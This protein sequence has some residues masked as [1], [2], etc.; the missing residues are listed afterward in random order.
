MNRL[1]HLPDARFVTFVSSFKTSLAQGEK[2]LSTRIWSLIG[3]GQ[4]MRRTLLLLAIIPMVVVLIALGL[5]ITHVVRKQIE[6]ERGEQLRTYAA[7]YAESLDQSVRRHLVDIKS[8]AALL[9]TFNLHDDHSQLATWMYTVQSQVTDYAWISFADRHGQ[10]RVSTRPTNPQNDVRATSWFQYGLTQPAVI[11]APT[12]SPSLDNASGPSDSNPK[13]IHLVA[14]VYSRQ[15]DVAGV[16]KGHLDWNWLVSQH[17]RF[18]QQVAPNQNIE[19]F[20]AAADGQANLVSADTTS[21][22]LHKIGSFQLAQTGDPG[23]R[24]ETWPDGKD[25]LVGYAKS[26]QL[27]GLHGA[28]WTTLVRVPAGAIYGPID[29]LI[30]GLWLL[31]I[32]TIVG[33]VLMTRLLLRVTLQPIEQLVSTINTVADH[34]GV[35]PTGG[36]APSEFQVLTRAANRMIQ[37]VQ[38]RETANQAKTQLIADI[39]H[40]IRTPLHGL[41]GHAELLKGRLQ[42]PQDQAD[43][44]RM[45]NCAKDMTALVND[46]ID[47]SA[48]EQREVQLNPQPILL[49]ELVEF[50]AEIFRSLATQQGLYFDLE[51]TA[52]A[53]LRLLADRLRFGQVLRNLFSNAVKFTVHGGVRVTVEAVPLDSK[54]TDVS[55]GTRGEVML[56]IDVRDSG[57]GIPK[58]QQSRIFDRYRRAHT[59]TADHQN[60]SKIGTGLGLSVTK[61][62]VESMRGS[63]V[64]ESEPGC[65]TRVT[66]DLKLRVAPADAATSEP[67]MLPKNPCGLRVL[68]IEDSRQNLDVMERWL[69]QQGHQVMTAQSGSSGLGLIIEQTFDLIL[70][71]IDLPDMNGREL[72]Q[73]VRNSSHANARAKIFAVSGLAFD[74]DRQASLAA[75][76]DQHISKPL[77]FDLFRHQLAL[78]K[79]NT[80]GSA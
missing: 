14:P 72:A 16:L 64:V 68:L 39:S 33:F 6:K 2:H 46:A 52:D 76:I 40:E 73:R 67:Q 57:I 7:Y 41:I 10:V 28:G 65:G 77:D 62:L 13:A 17:K 29:Q 19:V 30:N 58:D 51:I 1:L 25:Y 42:S 11:E 71:D 79:R 66:V 24:R 37:A 69:T 55:Q 26:E 54:E 50:N 15:S 3:N 27:Q 47:L 63:I 23:W 32:A 59:A 5:S 70:L 78:L 48:L 20:I 53:N 60:D 21:F 74:E 31:I 34:G 18:L 80:F 44:S 56:K 35:I 12:T 9:A 4:P 45:I 36:P 38:D 22:A 75:G 49:K 61:G 43:V 8:R